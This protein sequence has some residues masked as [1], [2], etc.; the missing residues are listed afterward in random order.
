MRGAVFHNHDF[1]PALNLRTLI[2]SLSQQEATTG[3]EEDHPAD[4][5][6]STNGRVT[7]KRRRLESSPGP[8]KRIR[9]DDE[10]R[11]NSN[12]SQDDGREI[13][14]DDVDRGVTGRQIYPSYWESSTDVIN[15]A[16]QTEQTSFLQVYRFALHLRYNMVVDYTSAHYADDNDAANFGWVEEEKK[17]CSLLEVCQRNASVPQDIDMGRFFMTRYH[18][19]L[20][21]LSGQVQEPPSSFPE[22]AKEHSERWLCLLPDIAW[23]DGLAEGDFEEHN[24]QPLGIHRE[25]ITACTVLQSHHRAKLEGSLQLHILPKGTYDSTHDL[26]FELRAHFTLSLANT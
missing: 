12:D 14:K 8:S 3:G 5:E 9:L 22:M 21:A 17:L 26:P 25:F 24:T 18:G 16:C 13:D 6:P 20:L 4:D 11:G 23:P 7:R 15:E 2:S 19:R 1:R 10:A